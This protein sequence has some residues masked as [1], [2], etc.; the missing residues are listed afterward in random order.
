MI[1][2]SLRQGFGRVYRAV[3][4]VMTEFAVGILGDQPLG[5]AISAL[6]ASGN[7]VN[8]NQMAAVEA[9]LASQASA[10]NIVFA[11]MARRAALNLNTHL[12]ATDAFMRI[13]LRAQ[14]QCRMT[15]ETLTAIKNP[16]TVFAKQA[17]IANEPQQVNNG[18]PDNSCAREN[19]PAPSKQLEQDHLERL[20]A[21]AK[22]AAVEGDSA[23]AAMDPVNWPAK[24]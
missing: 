15:L 8:A 17:N 4:K 6:K 13:A 22:S 2:E 16:P 3:G 10:L 19:L 11:V 1:L 7:A 9:I 14:N 20:D 24:R 5:E 18:I 23:L 12:D 21:R